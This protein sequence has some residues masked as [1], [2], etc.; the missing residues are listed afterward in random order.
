[1]SVTGES[2]ELWRRLV[3]RYLEALILERGLSPRT[4][5]AYRNDLD[6]YGRE[7]V[8]AGRD[9]ARAPPQAV[10]KHLGAPRRHGRQA[11][12]RARGQR[13]HMSELRGNLGRERR[14]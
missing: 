11:S 6:R 2:E 10:A 4:V 9:P 7:T 5:D 3:G 14:S 12:E 13:T 8:A 1:M